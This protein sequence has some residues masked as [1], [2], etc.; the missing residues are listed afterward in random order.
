MYQTKKGKG[1]GQLTQTETDSVVYFAPLT[2][3][4]T[5]K[6]TQ[7]CGKRLIFNQAKTLPGTILSFIFSVTARAS[8]KSIIFQRQTKFD[9]F[10]N[11]QID[12]LSLTQNGE[13]SNLLNVIIHTSL[14]SQITD[15]FNNLTM[16]LF[17]NNMYC[18]D[19][20]LRSYRTQI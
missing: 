5:G 2:I 8:S 19:V 15:Y 16:Q 14:C 11:V 18:L 6:K 4:H 7:G 17:G 20:L 10:T 3:R 1:R 9:S 12:S 13:L